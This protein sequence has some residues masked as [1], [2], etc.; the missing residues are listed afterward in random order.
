MYSHNL[1]LTECLGVFHKKTPYATGPS[2]VWALGTILCNLVTGRNPW[3]IASPKTDQGFRFYLRDGAS[4]LRQHLAI[5]VAASELLARIFQCLRA[6]RAALFS[7]TVLL[8]AYAHRLVLMDLICERR[9]GLSKDGDIRGFNEILAEERTPLLVR[10][11]FE[12][13]EASELVYR[14]REV[15][16]VRG[17]V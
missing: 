5:S 9:G 12:H 7:Q 15:R 4:W 11:R 1:R 13:R 2:D 6:R 17:A 3:H 14:G 16:T 10:P 8:V